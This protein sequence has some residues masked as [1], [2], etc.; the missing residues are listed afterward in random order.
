MNYWSSNGLLLVPC[1]NYEEIRNLYQTVQSNI[2][3]PHFILNCSAFDLLKE[4]SNP[5][6]F[7]NSQSDYFISESQPVSSSDLTWFKDGKCIKFYNNSLYCDDVKISRKNFLLGKISTKFKKRKCVEEVM[8]R[9]VRKKCN[10][11][12]AR[13][14]FNK[15]GETLPIW[16]SKCPNK[17]IDAIDV[18]N[19]RCQCGKSLPTFNKL[20][21][22]V[23]IW[24]AKCPNKYIDAVDV[25]NK[26]CQCGKS[27][28]SFNKPGESVPTW[29]AKCPTKSIDA[30]DVKHKR[31]QCGKAIPTF[32]RPGESAPIWCAKCPNKP[33]DA[34]DVKNKRCQCGKARPTFNIPGE[35]VPIWCAKCPNKYIDAIN[36]KNKKCQCGKA[37]PTFNKPGESVPI[38]CAKCP[39]KSIDA[40]NVKNKRC[41]CG[42]SAPS[43]NN[44]GE[45]V[46]IWCAKCP[47]KSLDAID[48]KNKRCLCKKA[49]AYFNIPGQLPLCC[50]QCKTSKMVFL[51]TKKCSNCQNLAIFGLFARQ[52]CEKHKLESDF[53]YAEEICKS[54]G[55][56]EILDSDQNCKYCNPAK[57]IKYIKQKENTI[58]DVLLANHFKFIQDKIPN[59]TECG[60]ERPDFLFDVGSH[61]VILEVDENQH[62]HYQKECEQ[63]RMFNIT[64]TFGGLPVFWIRYNP[65]NFKTK[66]KIIQ[67]SDLQKH[68]HLLDWLHLSFKRNMTI[69]SEVVYLFYDGCNE[70]SNEYD[71]KILSKLESIKI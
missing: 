46:P 34:I 14:T 7:I 17:S 16:C 10:C 67:V 69:L 22:S 21:E 32:N 9:N 53:N 38:W 30:I 37:E 1:K 41:Q 13:P 24:C 56:Q 52:R 8:E 2:I 59:G 5:T 20:G 3:K 11:G 70:K 33:I 51:P 31:C 47:N 61:I 45:S 44:P 71:I 4:L 35:S 58:K 36:V 15:P 54:C 12:R 50:S 6:K 39:N 26:R 40:I 57:F 48:L 65:D 19:K 28:P 55:L 29:C 66:K 43:F 68:K 64:Q 27:V 42:K 18:K 49:R 62:K 60:R 23:P 63:I 25:V